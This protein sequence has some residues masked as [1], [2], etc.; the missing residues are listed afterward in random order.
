MPK[1][2][3]GWRQGV[4]MQWGNARKERCWRWCVQARLLPLGQRDD[5]RRAPAGGVAGIVSVVGI[6]RLADKGGTRLS[7]NVVRCGYTKL[8]V[9]RQRSACR[10]EFKA[11]PRKGRC[12]GQRT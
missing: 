4:V 7:K 8:R 3:Q 1:S 10:T 12:A 11:E 6:I 5:V 2:S 9:L